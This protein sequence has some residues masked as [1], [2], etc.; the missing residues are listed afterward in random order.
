M[1]KL[2]SELVSK[3]IIKVSH[4]SIH[5]KAQTC[6]EKNVLPKSPKAKNYID[7][8]FHKNNIEIIFWHFSFMAT[9]DWMGGRH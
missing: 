5:D 4:C 3:S 2:K 7:A 9:G 1:A 6:A 8:I